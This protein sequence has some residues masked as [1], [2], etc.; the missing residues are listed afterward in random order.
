MEDK[1]Y[2]STLSIFLVHSIKFIRKEFPFSCKF[3][4]E[5]TIECNFYETFMLMFIT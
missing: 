4:A 3:N 5:I 1:A 2:N